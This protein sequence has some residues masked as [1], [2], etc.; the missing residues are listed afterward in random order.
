MSKAFTRESDDSGADETP[1]VRRALP[2][3]TRNYITPEGAERLR[4]RMNALLER[5][6]SLRAAAG[7]GGTTAEAD[8]RKLAAAIYSLEQV[9]G[10][11]VV[12][13]IPE[14][15]GKV[16]FGATVVI[17]R[18]DGEEERY[19]IVGVDEAEPENG[20]ISWISPLARALLTRRAGEKVR[21]RE[22]ELTILSV[23]Y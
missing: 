8:E 14:D 6:Q 13:G 7:E 2:A 18:G 1:M 16:A 19:R 15:R 5:K 22:E 23:G 3:G 4:Q 10:S 12:P 20:A 21:F 9:L 17:R 11:V